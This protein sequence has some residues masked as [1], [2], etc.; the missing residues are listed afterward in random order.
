MQEITH[1]AC[2][3]TQIKPSPGLLCTSSGD[4]PLKRI[5]TQEL[6]FY[7]EEIGQKVSHSEA[8]S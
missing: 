5:F 8:I 7:Q 4:S 6:G 2:F 1:R 3:H